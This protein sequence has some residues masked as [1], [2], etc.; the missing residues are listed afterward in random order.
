MGAEKPEPD[1]FLAVIENKITLLRTLADSYRA[2]VAA[3][4]LAP[5]DV[6]AFGLAPQFVS[7]NDTSVELP[8]GALLGKSLPTAIKLY[9]S[10]IKKKQTTREITTALRDG[11]IES[12]A[13]SFENNVTSAL[14]RL[15]AV[16]D[17]LKF[18]D[19]WGLAKFYP[20]N[21]RNRI[22]AQSDAKPK[23]RAHGKRSSGAAK[24]KASKARPSKPAAGNSID[25]RFLAYL[26][27]RPSVRFT[28]KQVGEAF[29]ETDPK[30]VG[31]AFARL[32]RHGKVARGAD[33]LYS[34]PRP[35]EH[36]KAV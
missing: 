29:G 14:H 19:G 5:G 32:V 31:M 25:Q 36:M 6:D 35:A 3:G 7:R 34:A 2:V 17:V 1:G 21:L 13:A 9:L 20:E 30:A 24:A 10:A 26:A 22:A 28:P 18:N 16:G 27:A 12:T 23:K 4:A 8:Q 15:K 11:G 33:G